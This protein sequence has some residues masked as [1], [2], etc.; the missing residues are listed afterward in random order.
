MERTESEGSD[1][2]LGES[3][4]S[5]RSYHADHSSSSLRHSSTN[6]FKPLVVDE[7]E[8]DSAVAAQHLQQRCASPPSV[9]HDQ[10]LIKGQ[11][12]PTDYREAVSCPCC[13]RKVC[14]DGQRI[15]SSPTNSD[16]NSLSQEDD[17]QQEAALQQN[18]STDED[19]NCLGLLNEGAE[20][21]ITKV[22]AEGWV[23]KKGSGHD[24]ISS[25]AWKARWARLA[26]AKVP[27]HEVDVPLLLIYWYP[28]TPK[29]ST[30]II[31]DSTV[32]MPD[33]KLKATVAGK[34]ILWNSYRFE[35]K[36]VKKS[37]A[38]LA[39]AASPGQESVTRTFAV[40]SKERDEWV[41][42]ISRALLDYE[43]RRQR[44]LQMERQ[45]ARSPPMVPDG[46]KWMNHPSLA[47][48]RLATAPLSP[49]RSPGG[50]GGRWMN[51][52]LPPRSPP[53][54][55]SMASSPLTVEIGTISI[56]QD[57]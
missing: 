36:H 45:F 52:E 34:K 29:P 56:P 16:D 53:R 39:A 35:I 14:D 38:T 10:S 31:L 3:I 22:L 13:N 41:Y 19:T 51:D 42:A 15:D 8:L 43:K 7:M 28:S 46:P 9:A 20:Y 40:P 30:V 12:G 57:Q 1:M 37:D 49:P 44:K 55:P 11:I 25:R 24:W 47:D 27:G 18:G 23:H 54:S 2:L 6:S 50:K 32:V 4:L 17:H 5:D 33:D 26:L 48:S 21:D